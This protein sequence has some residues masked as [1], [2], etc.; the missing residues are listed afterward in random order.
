MSCLTDQDVSDRLQGLAEN[1]FKNCKYR[2]K[3]HVQDGDIL[4]VPT[5]Y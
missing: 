1:G 4:K 5:F 3:E 2:R